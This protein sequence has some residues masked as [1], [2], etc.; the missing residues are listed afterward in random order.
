M[1]FTLHDVEYESPTG[2]AVLLALRSAAERG[3]RI[4]IVHNT[5]FGLSDNEDVAALAR[6][7]LATVRALNMEGFTGGGV[8]H[9]KMMVVDDESMYVGSANMDWRSLQ[10]VKELGVALYRCAC[11]SRDL[12]RVFRVYW[13]GS[14][15]SGTAHTGMWDAPRYAVAAT[16]ERPVLVQLTYSAAYTHSDPVSAPDPVTAHHPVARVFLASAP[17]PLCPPSMT[18]DLDALLYSVEKARERISISVMDYLPLF[19]YGSAQSDVLDEP[20][21]R[22][23]ALSSHAAN[24]ASNQRV[25]EEPVHSYWPIIDDAIRAAAQER[26]VHVRMLLSRWDHTKELMYAYAR[27]LDALPFVDV[28]LLELPSIPHQPPYTRV[29]HAKYFVTESAAFIGTSNWSADYFEHTAGVSV[30]IEE[31]TAVARVQAIFDRDWFS[32]YSFALDDF[33]DT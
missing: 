28:R 25:W 31:R 12:V 23:S 20:E 30:T 22:R 33:D 27:S 32:E 19:L 2:D 14:V 24:N 11:V 21:Q 13:D 10:E 16:A 8:L 17:P 1:Y 6:E 29:N 4:R 5:N 9:T 3:V 26:H 7:G 18:S 15:R